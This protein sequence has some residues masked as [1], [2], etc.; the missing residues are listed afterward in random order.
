MA[1]DPALACPLSDHASDLFVLVGALIFASAFVCL[2]LLLLWLIEK[3]I[4]SASRT[5]PLSAI[6][7]CFLALVLGCIGTFA[8]PSFESVYSTFEAGLPPQTYALFRMRYLLWAPAVLLGVA[9][10]LGHTKNRHYFKSAL[11]AE[12]ILLVLTLQALY[13]GVVKVC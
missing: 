8:V 7:T 1:I 12:A 3:A 5:F 4:F 10:V 13:A 9:H 6:A 11:F 2:I